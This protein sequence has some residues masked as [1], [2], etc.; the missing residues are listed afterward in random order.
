VQGQLKD[1]LLPEVFKKILAE[2]L[3][4]KLRIVSGPLEKCIFFTN[5][6][7]TFATSNQPSEKLGELL[8]RDGV[9]TPHDKDMAHNYPI[10]GKRFGDT[11]VEMGKLKAEDLPV[12][13]SRQVIEI[14]TSVF[15]LQDGHY[16]FSDTAR[17][18][19]EILIRDLSTPDI[20][21]EGIRKMPYSE[22]MKS[23]LGSPT[24]PM[25][26]TSDAYRV[27]EE[28]KLRPTEGFV[29]S[30]IDGVATLAEIAP[31]VPAE[32]I[33]TYKMLYG[34]RVLGFLS[35]GTQHAKTADAVGESK[36]GAGPRRPTPSASDAS[37]AHKVAVNLQDLESL[38]DRVND[39]DFY[40]LLGVARNV[41]TAEVK[42]A[43]YRQAKVYH[44]DRFRAAGDP[45][46]VKKASFVFGK[47]TE[48]YEVLVDPKS[49]A[50][51]DG[52]GVEEKKDFARY[53][54]RRE[55]KMAEKENLT[56]AAQESYQKGLD[57]YNARKYAEAIEPLSQAVK[58]APKNLEYALALAW[59]MAKNPPTKKDAEKAFLRAVN[60]DK[61][62]AEPYVQMGKF[63]KENKDYEK[64]MALFQRAITMDDEHEE[65]KK[66]ME[67]MPGQEGEK[68]SFWSRLTGR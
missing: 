38:H 36:S 45:D 53:E 40:Q 19:Q 58:G 51:Y 57:L 15:L 68:K 44:P 59:A 20:I 67:S 54:E 18:P 29:L 25:K 48:A 55:E 17:A 27:A 16:Y 37:G 52:A 13:L 7:I 28:V 8:V 10:P 62:N 1:K 33:E 21:M 30:R 39:I 43:Y 9:I 65:C 2:H 66:E 63:Y 64:A 35:S 12:A 46:I 4:G 49:R 50:T 11:L 42:R 60:I 41:S 22:D 47:M 5:G 61:L 26:L 56:K 23:S 34:L 32:E 24:K 3:T 6:K 14:A 31:L